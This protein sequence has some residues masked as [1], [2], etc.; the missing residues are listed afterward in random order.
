M[1]ILLLSGI[2]NTGLPLARLLQEAKQSFLI[3]SRSPAKLPEP[4]KGVAFDWFNPST[5]ENPFKADANIDRVYIVGPPVLD[6]LPQTKDFVE[7]AIAKGVKRFVLLSAAGTPR[8]GLLN[9]KVH[10]YLA[11]RGVDYAVLRPTWFNAVKQGLVASTVGN[12]KIAFVSAD[13]VAAV[14]FRALVDEKSHNTEHIIVGP[15]LHTY[16]EAAALLSGVLGRTII[17]KHLTHEEGK[18]LFQ[19]V[20]LPEDYAIALLGLEKQIADGEEE[21]HFHA[22]VK[23]VGKVH[24]KEYFEAN[25]EAFVA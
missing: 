3:A 18:A 22:E 15:E 10:E 5:Y 12:G 4:F 8:G 2:G 16:D 14:A 21:T 23:E 20:P 13:D 11:E 9:G 24:L 6:K 19:S 25:R 7:L 1:T 17:Y